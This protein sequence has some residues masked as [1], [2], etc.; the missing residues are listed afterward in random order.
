MLKI[1]EN[2]VWDAFGTRFALRFDFGSDFEA[3]FADFNG[4]WKDSNDFLEGFF[5]GIT[6][7]CERF[8]LQNLL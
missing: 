3:I 2:W 6:N 1:G 4:F 7:D 5:G 8:R